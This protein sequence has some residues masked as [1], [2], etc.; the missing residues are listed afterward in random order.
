LGIAENGGAVLEVEIGV[1]FLGQLSARPFKRG[2][3]LR[4]LVDPLGPDLV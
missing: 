4:E 2:Q 1:V 3:E